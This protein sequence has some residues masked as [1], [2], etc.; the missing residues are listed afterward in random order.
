MREKRGS[1]GAMVAPRRHPP[2]R[3]APEQLP[4][5]R[6]DEGGDAEIGDQGSVQRADRGADRQREHDGQDPDRRMVEPKIF[7]Q[8]IDLSDAD[9]G[10]DE[11]DDRAD[12]QVDV[13][14][15]DD[16][17]HAGRHHR[18]R[19]GLDRQ[20]PEIARRQEQAFA[21]LDVGVDVE[22]DPDQRQ[23]R[24]HA[25]HAGVDLGRP[26]QPFEQ[27]LVRNFAPGDWRC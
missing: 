12:R 26:H 22:A 19:R 4:A 17:H 5:Q 3:A 11:S 2:R 20:V 10:R 8:E 1:S 21:G 16:Q 18:D 14:H 24:D 27:R 7:R 25:D 9:D 6:D 23:R 15:D 13:A